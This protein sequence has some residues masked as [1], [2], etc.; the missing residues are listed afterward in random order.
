VLANFH[1]LRLEPDGTERQIGDTSVWN[2]A[3]FEMELAALHSP[4]WYAIRDEQSGQQIAVNL[5]KP[6]KVQGEEICDHADNFCSL[7][8]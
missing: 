7:R 8:R 3:V 6:K 2:L 4:G 1:I 5:S